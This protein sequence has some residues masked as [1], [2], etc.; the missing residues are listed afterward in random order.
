MKWFI[1]SNKYG[2]VWRGVSLS[3]DFALI[4]A[5][6]TLGYESLESCQ[7]AGVKFIVEEVHPGM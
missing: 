3:K 5:A 2:V 7:R 1:V 4:R 6:K